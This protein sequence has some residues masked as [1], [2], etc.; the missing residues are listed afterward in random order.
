MERLAKSLQTALTS[1]EVAGV[2]VCLSTG[3]VSTACG[4]SHTLFIK[5]PGTYTV[6]AVCAKRMFDVPSLAD[7]DLSVDRRLAWLMEQRSWK[8]LAGEACRSAPVTL[9]VGGHSQE[10]QTSKPISFDSAPPTACRLELVGSTND[11]E[12]LV[13]LRHTNTDHADLYL[14]EPVMRFIGDGLSPVRLWLKNSDGALLQ[15]LSY[16][17]AAWQF[18]APHPIVR[19][20]PGG[21]ICKKHKVPNTWNHFDRTLQAVYS[22]EL[23]LTKGFAEYLNDGKRPPKG[24]SPDDYGQLLLKGRPQY[25]VQSNVLELPAAD[26]GGNR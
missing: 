18:G 3:P 8:K 2:G 19:L 9:V 23:F 22:E 15:D 20:P 7:A 16:A 21:F 1:N 14:Q 6:Q 4:N 10:R 12:A 25:L 17:H 24:I 13:M 11:G 26:V 5:T